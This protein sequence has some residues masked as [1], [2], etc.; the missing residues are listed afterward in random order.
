[1][2]PKDWTLLV[3]AAAQPRPLQPVHLQK[4]LFLLERKLTPK[5]LQ[6]K[7]F[8]RFEA[9]DY[10]PFCPEVYLHAEALR[11]E[12]LVNI[13]QPAFQS[14][15]LYSTTE[16]GTA[17]A[18]DLRQQLEQEVRTYL[19]RLVDWACSLSFKQLVSAIYREF[20]DMKVNSVFQE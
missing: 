1:M 10:G 20:P 18:G 13:E 9:Y 5:E 12:G 3:V 4:S 8:Y 7:R 16:A 15:R 17:R 2:K 19:D 11:D 6:V 14:Y